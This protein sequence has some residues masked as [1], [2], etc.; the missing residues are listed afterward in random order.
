VG[1]VHI[2]KDPL[3][4]MGW[5]E[6]ASIVEHARPEELPFPTTTASACAPP[7]RDE[8]AVQAAQHDRDAAAREMVRDGVHDVD[9]AVNEL[10]AH[11]IEGVLAE[12]RGVEFGAL[13]VRDVVFARG[14]SGQRQ[15]AERRHAR[16]TH[17]ARSTNPGSVTPSL[18]KR[19]LY[20]RNTAHCDHRPILAR[21]CCLPFGA[22]PSVPSG[23]DIEQWTQQAPRSVR[24]TDTSYGRRT[25][26]HADH[27]RKIG[28]C[29]G[30]LLE[31][32]RRAQ[33]YLHD[34][35]TTH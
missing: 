28:G 29:H 26:V 8:R 5:S 2:L 12:H 34:V 32:A 9:L 24:L 4:Y 31:I 15:Q 17:A 19:S 18:C 22:S 20:T 35:I 6:P 11:E 25:P 33:S 10:N 30:H 14:R 1:E 23:A 21:S 3:R 27:C 7:L 16:D 13:E